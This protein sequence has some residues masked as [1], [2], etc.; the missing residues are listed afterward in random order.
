MMARR[1]RVNGG[2]MSDRG[3]C[4]QMNVKYRMQGRN[5]MGEDAAS[6]VR[7]RGRPYNASKTRQKA[8]HCK[9]PG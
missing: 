5:G 8:R 1:E 2:C 4:Q 9:T 3:K 6:R 7:N